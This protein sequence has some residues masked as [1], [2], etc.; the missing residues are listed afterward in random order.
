MEEAENQNERTDQTWIGEATGLEKRQ[1]RAR[2][3]VECWCV[4]YEQSIPEIILRP[5]RT[6]VTA[7]RTAKVSIFNVNRR[8]R[9]RTSGGVGGRGP[10]GPLLLD[11]QVRFPQA[12]IRIEF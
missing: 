10:R 1:Q 8:M 6:R 2:F 3:V 5:V 12:H 9:N 11:F 4:A 7:R